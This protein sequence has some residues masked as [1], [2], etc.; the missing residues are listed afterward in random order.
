MKHKRKQ[1]S[2]RG[3]VQVQMGGR[4]VGGVQSKR[5]GAHSATNRNWRH[6]NSDDFPKLLALALNVL[7]QLIHL[8]T[9]RKLCAH[10]GERSR[11]GKGQA[12]PQHELKCVGAQLLSTPGPTKHDQ[13][14]T[15]ALWPYLGRDGD[16]HELNDGGGRSMDGEALILPLHH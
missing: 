1:R 2:V 8:L 12:T 5:G 7:L 9:G 6:S 13:R 4:E 14:H 3:V 10:E 11:E 16:P 15:T